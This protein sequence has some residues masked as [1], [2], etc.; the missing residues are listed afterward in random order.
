MQQGMFFHSLYDE[1]SQAYI[2]QVQFS[3]HGELNRPA[4]VEA[5]QLVLGRHPVLRT[6]L[7]WED[8]EEPYQVV[9]ANVKVPMIEH[10]W[11]EASLEEQE[12][13]FARLL[14]ADR[15][16]AFDLKVA[17]LMRV[18]L[19][20]L[21]NDSH[22]VLWTFHHLL[23][24]GWSIPLVIQDL[25][26]F[27]NAVDQGIQPQLPEVRPY[28][29]YSEWLEAQDMGKVEQFWRSNLQ[30]FTAPTALPADIER[31]TEAGYA[32]ASLRLSRN[33][34]DILNRFAR[35]CRITPNTLFQSAW[36]LLLSSCS[37]EEDVLYGTTVSGRPA[38]LPGVE[39]MVGLFINTLPV[40]VNVSSDAVLGPW[41]R[42]AQ[43]RQAELRLYEYSP[44]L[45]V[46]G[47]SDVPRGTPLFDSLFVFENIQ[48]DSKTWDV[49]D[50]LSVSDQDA[51]EQP[52]LPLTVVVLPGKEILLRMLYD[53]SR[54]SEKQVHWLL[55]RLQVVLEAMSVSGEGVMLKDLPFITAEEE[56]MIVQQWN[57]TS[58]A[59][60]SEKTIHQL[61]EEQV[62]ARPEHAALYSE[63]M[64]WSYMELNRRANAVARK[65]VELGIRNEQLIPMITHRSPDMVIGMLA[66]LKAG[67]AYVP[68]DPAY[69]SERIEVIVE[70]CESYLLLAANKNSLPAFTFDGE[71]VFMDE[72]LA[73]LEQAGEG[74]DNLALDAAPSNL[75]YV[76]YT[77][78]STGRPKG[79]MIEHRNV[80]RLVK[81]SNYVQFDEQTC[82]LQTGAVVFDAATLEVWGALLNGGQLVVLDNDTI[83]DGRR[84]K[85][86]IEQYDVNTMFITAPLLHQ[87][88]QQDSSIFNRLHTLMTGGDVL[89]VPHMNRLLQSNPGLTIVNAYGPTENTTISTTFSFT[90]EQP[91]AI[92]IGRPIANSSAYVVDRHLR[93]LPP[94][95]KGELIV[96]GDGVARGYRN[97]PDLT[98]EKFIESPFRQE[99]R[100]YRTGDLVR[101]REDGI[102]EFIGRIDSQVK[103]RGFRIEPGEIEHVLVSHPQVKEA[104]VIAVQAGKGDKRLVAYTVVE[105]VD[106]AVTPDILR[107]YLK[108]D[109]PEHMIPAAFVL[110][111]SFPL[112][113]NGKVDRRSLPAPDWR[114]NEHRDYVPARNDTEQMLCDI[115]AKVLG[116]EQVGIYDNFFELG[117]DSILSIQVVTQAAQL[118]LRLTPKQIFEHRLIAELAE[119]V[120][121]KPEVNAEQGEVTGCVPL[122]PIQRWFFKQQFTDAHHWNQAMM[123]T[124]KR[125]IET[126]MLEQAFT[127]LL[128]HHDALRMR[129]GNEECPP[130]ATLAAAEEIKIHNIDVSFL[131]V[132]EQNQVIEQ[133]SAELQASLNLH[134]GPLVRVAYFNRG[135]KS[136]PLLLIII[137]HLAVDGVSWRILLEDLETLCNQLC[138][139]QPVKLPAKTTSYK[140]WG[141]VLQHYAHSEAVRE[142][143]ASWI[144][145]SNKKPAQL[146]LDMASEENLAAV[147]TV[148]N[149]TVH[150]AVLSE[151]DSLALLNEV[152]GIARANVPELL[153]SAI[154]LAMGNW[155]GKRELL[156]HMEG[157]GREEIVE[158]VDLSRTVGWFTTMY[159]VNLSVVEASPPDAVVKAV[160]E[161]LRSIP[162]KGIGY[163]LLRYLSEDETYAQLQQQ[164]PADI[165]FNYLGRFYQA[166]DDSALFDLSTLSAG[167]VLSHHGHRPHILDI[168]VM[169]VEDR[170]HLYITYCQQLHKKTT[171]T[172][173]AEWI[174][175][176][177]QAL[178]QAALHTPNKWFTP[179]DFPLAILSQHQLERLVGSEGALA[180]K[181]LQDIYPLSSLQAGM[182]Y[183]SLLEEKAYAYCQQSVF[184][185]RGHVRAALFEN[186]WQQVIDKHDIFRTVFV[187]EGVD[188]PHQAVIERASLPIYWEDW[189]GVPPHEQA[190]K[191]DILLQE[192]RDRKYNLLAAPLMRITMIRSSDDCYKMVWSFHHI[193]LDGWSLQLVWGEVLQTYESAVQGQWFASHRPK[194]YK[195]F[196]RWTR[197]KNQHEAEAFWRDYLQGV[198]PGQLA[199]MQPSETEG[200]G[201]GGYAIK[202]SA[203]V[204]NMLQQLARSHQLTMGILVQGAWAY[205]LS[206]YSG[207]DQVLFGVTVAGRPTDIQ[208][209]DSMIG[210]FINTLPMKATI[211]PS[212]RLVDWLERLQQDLSDI[213]QYEHSSL[214]D[215]QGWSDVP[216]GTPLIESL[217][218]FENYPTDTAAQ[219][220]MQSLKIED[221]RAYENPDIPLTIA[222]VPGEEMM[223]SVL[224][225]RSR[226]SPAE[227][228]RLLGH[229]QA[230]LEGMISNPMQLLGTLDIL[231]EQERKQLIVECNDTTVEIPDQPIHELF[232]EQVA[233]RPD[234]HA[235]ISKSR[236]IT[237]RELDALSNSLANVLKERGIK[238]EE[239]IP[240]MAERSPQMII[241]MLAILK[242]GGAYV[243]IDPT[244]PRERIE[245]MLE[246]TDVRLLIVST[247]DGLPAFS[248]TGEVLSIDEMSLTTE[249][250][251]TENVGYYGNAADLAY[252]MYTSGSTGRPKGVMVEQRNI[253]RL[254]KNI[255][256]VRLDENSRILQAGAVV[257]DASTFEIWGALLNGGQVY[258]T[259]NEVILDGQRLKQEIENYRINTMFLTTALLHQHV[260]QDSGIFQ[261]LDTLLAGGETISPQHV[262][263]L[264]KDN[265]NLT[266]LHVYGPTENTTF[267]TMYRVACEHP[268]VVPIGSPIPNSTAYVVDSQLNLLPVGVPGELLVGGQG[269]ARGYWK[270]SDMT[271]KSFIPS[272]FRAGERCYRTGDLVRMNEDG[273]IEFIGRIDNQ[274]KIRGFRV[275]PGEIEVILL[276]HPD[277]QE[278]V[279][280]VREDEPGNKRLVAYLVAA[281][282]AGD[283]V[284]PDVLRQFAKEHLPEHMIPSAF[285]ILDTLPLTINGKV[286]R[287]ALPV[288]DY[289]SNEVEPEQLT[290]VQELLVSL[291]SRVLGV[292]HVR[293]TDDF[294]MLGGHSLMATQ[295]ISRIR[296]VFKVDLPLRAIFNYPTIEQFALQVEV[297]RKHGIEA[298]QPMVPVTRPDI[299]PLSYAQQRLWFLDQLEPDNRFYNIY[300]VLRLSGEFHIEAFELSLKQ[301]VKRHE[302]FRTT[303]VSKDGS[304][305][306]VIS[307]EVHVSVP[308]VDLSDV[309]KDKRE[310]AALRIAAEEVQRP[311][312]LTTDCLIRVTVLKLSPDDHVVVLVMHHIISDGW[313]IG[314]FVRELGTY[315]EGFCSGE[316][317]SL[318]DLSIQ[319]ADYALWQREWLQGTNRE[320]QLSYWTKKLEGIPTI[321]ELPA[322]YPRPPIQTFSGALVNCILPSKVV[323][324]LE[325]LSREEGATLYMTL[326][327]AFQVLLHRYSGQDS[328]CIGIPVANRNRPEIESIIGF[329]VNMLP[330]RADFTAGTT[331]R[332][333]LQQ[334]RETTLEAFDHQDLP[335]EQLVEVMQ[336]ERS[337]THSPLFQVIF[338]L[339]TKQMSTIELPGLSTTPMNVELGESKFDLELTMV[340]VPEGML[341]SF[342]YNTALF[343]AERIERMMVHYCTLLEQMAAYPDRPVDEIRILTNEELEQ[344]LVKWNATAA[345]IPNLCSHERFEQ[346][347]I[348][349]PDAIALV[350]E[351]KT[352]TYREL[353]ERSNQLAHYLRKL[354]VAPEVL[355][356]ICANR[357]VEFAIALLAV[358]KAGGVY[359]PIDPDYPQERIAYMMEH[360]K[361]EFLLTQQHLLDRVPKHAARTVCLDSDWNS[362][363]QEPTTAIDDDASNVTQE[364][365]AYV[366]YTSGS[367]GEPKGVVVTH[368]SLINHNLS[369]SKVFGIRAEDRVLQFATISFDVALEEFFSAWT[370]GATVVM[371]VDRLMT[372]EAFS[373]FVDDY[374]LTVLNL[375]SAYWHEWVRDLVQTENKPPDCVRTVIV[376]SERPSPEHLADWRRIVGD[377]IAWF[378]AYGPSEATIT[379]TIFSIPALDADGGSH[380]DEIPIGRPIANTQVYLLDEYM[381]P[382]P[383]GI[384]GELYIG[385]NGLARG[386]LNK[387]ELTAERFIQH[388][389]GLDGTLYR[390]GDLARY[391]EDGNIEFLGRTDYQVKIRGF[392]IE[393]GEVEAALRQQLHVQDA[394]VIACEARPGEQRLVAYAV[395]QAGRQLDVNSLRNALKE[396]LP[397]YMV[398]A[399]I[400]ALSEL[401][402]T[403]AGKVDRRALP[404]PDWS[405]IEAAVEYAEPRNITE[406]QLCRIWQQVLGIARVGIH[407]NFFELGGDSI[408]SIQIVARSNQAGLKLTPR[409]MFQYQTVAELATIVEFAAPV[410][411]EQGI[412]TGEVSLTPIQQWFFEQSMTEPHH[413]N[414]AV[415]LTIAQPVNIFALEQAFVHLLNHHDVLRAQYERTG[416][417]WVQ[418]IAEASSAYTVDRFDLSALSADEQRDAL[419]AHADKLQASLNLT[420][421]PLFK[422][423]LFDTGATQPA[424]LL[425]FAH[426][427]VVDGVSWRIILEDVQAAYSQLIQ[428]QTVTLPLKTT[429]YTAWSTELQS[430]AQQPGVLQELSYWLEQSGSAELPLD[431]ELSAQDVAAA[432]TFASVQSVEVSLDEQETRMLL[433]DMPTVFKTQVNDV[434][435]T[436]LALAVKG[437][438][439]QE[440]VLIHLEGHGREE[441]V[442]DIDL[443]RTVG[444]F[445]AVYPLK[446]DIEHTNSQLDALK[447]VKEQ[448][449]LVPKHGIGY[450]LLRYLSEDDAV[451]ERL[452]AMAEPHIIFNYLG[453]FDQVMQD[454]TFSLAHES[455]GTMQ[456]PSSPRS[457]PIEIN[458]AV[459]GGKLQLTFMYSENLHKKETLERLAAG[460][461]QSVREILCIPRAAELSVL[462]PSDFPQALVDQQQLDTIIARITHLEDLYA[463]S[464]MQKGM[465]FHTLYSEESSTYFEQ[466]AFSIKG[467]LDVMQFRRA[468]QEVV[469]RH[470]ILRTQL[471]VN[472]VSEP[473][474]AVLAAVELPFVEVDWQHLA[475]EEQA[476][477]LSQ[478]LQEDIDRG[479]D[480]TQ[481][482]LMRITLFKEAADRHS[483]VWSHHHLLIDGWSVPII[484][485]EV[486]HMYDSYMK[487][488]AV[489]LNDVRPFRDYIAWLQEQDM[490]QAQAFWQDMLRG[491]SEPT[492]LP[493]K[494]SSSSSSIA[495][496]WKTIGLSHMLS[497]RLNQIA[498][499]QKVTLN[500]IVQAA[501]AILLSR[502]S[503]AE[504]VIY[505]TTVSGRPA[506]FAGV[507]SMVGLF[508]NTLPVRVA[509]DEEQAVQQWLNQLNKQIVDI[510]QF[511]YS[512]LVQVQ[513]WS[514]VPNGIPLFDSLVVFQ[515]YPVQDVLEQDHPDALQLQISRA[516]KQTNYPITLVAI[517]GDELQLQV[518]FDPKLF[519]ASSIES[520]L[521]HLGTLLEEM[522]NR[523]AQK[524]GN[525]QL[526]SEQE[527]KQTLMEWNSTS[528]ELPLDKTVAEWFAEQVRIQPDAVAIVSEEQAVTYGELSRMAERLAYSFIQNGVA[529]G[530]IVAI[531][532]ER[533][534][535]SV[536]GMLGIWKAGGAYLPL[537]STYPQERLSY[538]LAEAQV[539]VLLTQERVREQL[540]PFAGRIVV[541][542]DEL[543][544]VVGEGAEADGGFEAV[545]AAIGAQVQLPA[546]AGM[547]QLAYVI[548]TSG[549]TGQPKGVEITHRGLMNLIGWHRQTYDVQ[550]ADRATM[551]AGVA[552][553][554]SV[555]ELWPYIAAGASIYI[556]NEETRLNPVAL[557]DWL[558][559]NEITLSFIPTPL[560]EPMLTLEWPDKCK[561]RAILTGGDRLAQYPPDTLPFALYNH[562]GPSESTV[563]AAACQVPT[564]S[565]KSLSEI[566]PSIG[567]P[568]ANTRV[569]ILDRK[570]RPVP[571]GVPGEMY[572]GGEGL[573]RGYMNRP[574]LTA[575]RFIDSPFVQG[576]RLYR[577][578]DLA[579]HLP[580]G[581]I[582]FLGRND[583]Q[584]KIRGYRIE[585][586]EIHAAIAEHAAVREASVIVRED[587]PGDK[588]LVA[589]IVLH[590]K[591]QD[592][593]HDQH[594][595]AVHSVR[596]YLQ[597]RLPDYMVPL[598]FVILDALPLTANGKVDRKQLPAP[599]WE[600]MLNAGSYV[601]PRNEV[602]R[603]LT[604]IWE[605][606]L[607]IEQVGIHDNF[608][609]LGGDSIVS[610]QIIFRCT[611]AGLK[612]TPKDLFDHQ[613]IA[614][615]AEAVQ[616]GSEQG[617][618]VG[619][620]PLTPHQQWFFELAMTNPHHANQSRL[621]TVPESIDITL[622][623]QAFHSIIVHHDALRLRF[624]ITDGI[625]EQRNEAEPDEHI[626][627]FIDLF[628]LST[629]AQKE[630]IKRETERLQRSLHITEGPIIRAA[631]FDLGP[632]IPARLFI[633]IHHLAIDHSSWH[634]L[635][636]DLQTAYEQLSKDG[637]VKLPLKTASFKSWAE[638]LKSQVLSDNATSEPEF[639]TCMTQQEVPMLPVD[640]HVDLDVMADVTTMGMSSKLNL[641]LTEQETADLL[642]Q[643]TAA[644]RVEAR[645]ILLAALAV[646][647]SSWTAQRSL[648][649]ELQEERFID[650][651][652]LD[653][654]RSVGCFSYQFP[655]CLELGDSQSVQEVMAAV[656]EQ[657]RRVPDNGI[658][659][660]LL[661]Y[662]SPNREMA[663]QLREQ[664]KPSIRFTYIKPSDQTWNSDYFGLAQESIGADWSEHT[665]LDVALHIN[666]YL[667]DDQLQV[668]W[669][670]NAHLYER[671]TIER[672]MAEFAETLR[673]IIL[674]STGT[675]VDAYSAVDFAEFGWDQSE[676]DGFLD[677]IKKHSGS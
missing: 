62:A 91:G 280:I 339:Q 654:S 381:R 321:L 123:L 655:W 365:A 429:S 615:L 180:G 633:A 422:S 338:D 424:K 662:A 6:S 283:S 198:P 276:T 226:F 425:L 501:W 478:F 240:I 450:G 33:T 104:L 531:C 637:T 269:V 177:L 656:K 319:Y 352:I 458:A 642:H 55:H 324:E 497:A 144:A 238:R 1:G 18:T 438:T 156:V 613:T 454:G 225:E 420:E 20:R 359:V 543:Q 432:N 363:M 552:F 132:V 537:D 491:I 510:R 442:G 68:I 13:L 493:M 485:S 160:K 298:A 77:S 616:M 390:T 515:N 278:A 671:A 317:V 230:V 102:I 591:Q 350:V 540:P 131:D 42:Q 574:D 439:G 161:Q 25:F 118:G 562:Y 213:R 568:I 232:R 202:L 152:P 496:D 446:I 74:E 663:R 566:A 524:I 383:I 181:T 578:G 176:E 114:A 386:Y 430:F 284:T 605:E 255:N 387:P 69:P 494:R 503:G 206:K 73:S 532:M 345:N 179:S 159:P 481:A 337:L 399:M 79:V 362:I 244:Y 197:Q 402:M 241:A 267:S 669:C 643:A 474:Q 90:T 434:L 243:P 558:L 98:E 325:K 626:L 529:S 168:N 569:Y 204:T 150:T 444:W 440:A 396:K 592:D 482:P 14:A 330:I 621:L 572:V 60:P 117:G 622:L 354:G 542:E 308:I 469:N 47:W 234:D 636:Q 195:E 67:G 657:L 162:N 302:T 146:P 661:K 453:Q 158:D 473:H 28:G 470:S 320:V 634:I 99:E 273:Q 306:Q 407:D 418:K 8:V 506:D 38:N 335:F 504:E 303:F 641:S 328:L 375:P 393:L 201:T 141:E 294:F 577:T 248:F 26:S 51:L 113:I 245:F 239:L 212:L 367:T 397:I 452:A 54:F 11:G 431:F 379:S 614:L 507:E 411:A 5:W 652:K 376:G 467:N 370:S 190:V 623:S 110:L 228:E 351:N 619:D 145:S 627:E 95:M 629:A 665:Q 133:T 378:N 64:S 447:K 511:E 268:D 441:L 436:A 52:D 471:V 139:N 135:S 263:R 106:A 581:D 96:G 600:Q 259:D 554:A 261:G 651:F 585:L 492:P 630:A 97:R 36:A 208:G 216:R 205:L 111:D 545:E 258:L 464:P 188:E 544:A 282:L 257:F 143:A 65:L 223:L 645:E 408:L 631:L 486:V 229:L 551:L 76:M 437:W 649:V 314:V 457:N 170:I 584:V 218:V 667:H 253:I 417:G 646:T 624:A 203:D 410:Q 137:H 520:M 182:L 570:L 597:E 199:I 32:Q 670:Y 30:G 17:P 549:S 3:L 547:D 183:E 93:L 81:H 301:I 83:L 416:S 611:Q 372:I 222:A 480:L 246:D 525:L 235:V 456:S 638:Q 185:L 508:I 122:L 237:Y 435:L 120:G 361:L 165:S 260:T 513:G 149:S 334:V 342:N 412:V 536:A 233:K 546:A 647:I 210:L 35:K 304:P 495:A 318:P 579:R 326:L 489:E 346:L 461:V 333:M 266:F 409:Q 262:N 285:I 9:Q 196:I 548:F 355:V 310:K 601:A 443:S 555:W 23:L 484:L 136:D 39:A 15:E 403:P 610:I 343:Q 299:L 116:V 71:V 63:G 445:T 80:I 380:Y 305:R 50:R 291:W 256:Y 279:V 329:F 389:L 618:V 640:R 107:D 142:E 109:L 567:R 125:P 490:D 455:T 250:A 528:T 227:M 421:G 86:A 41:L 7:V 121:T 46:Q 553:D 309:S 200:N 88:S 292:S 414:Q 82:M 565:S 593:Q 617:P 341:A 564:Q 404:A 475:A 327:T 668:E 590:Q 518:L 423:V 312:D 153:L 124:V 415:M 340:E 147:N 129:F 40:R 332:D 265:P 369:V 295:L 264:L 311:F 488:A 166:V 533:S 249:Q 219:Q 4:F 368:G 401:P 167:S 472:G 358:F 209:A 151:S 599:A 192:D 115:W 413:W 427:L 586:G 175:R 270:R 463:L 72:V 466:T 635:L 220:G 254:V 349:R 296:E 595:G 22:R 290:V 138:D 498:R 676:L 174:E 394:V 48:T 85:Q 344:V 659:Y 57:D 128:A 377:R 297:A 21:K 514:D 323:L 509:I 675:P 360:S 87:L 596:S 639:W 512:P 140:R 172:A 571:Q 664:A 677:A 541:A 173:F 27:Y 169:V 653:L 75:A 348:Q 119:Y 588:R 400:V 37:G 287:R 644:F 556:A 94:G 163:G 31:G 366:I 336:P 527:R 559:A 289:T 628:D 674:Q 293:I 648:F 500:T 92:P 236:V 231:T 154:V 215:I 587:R 164:E 580:S 477:R 155:T 521:R 53:V 505:G 214:I 534:I 398:P 307:P 516:Y 673:T 594:D 316:A 612:L 465:L 100:C 112:M 224:Y 59:Y 660:G 89:S 487:D 650:K 315:Y 187:W 127:H 608:F 134:D 632:G 251:E 186:A 217:V 286:D 459:S 392:R 61:F 207:N 395:P 101:Y 561:L 178:I 563:V 281:E 388:P 433:Q 105:Q 108:R 10:N 462:T 56:Q 274:V 522:A 550:A 49:N 357:S 34:T 242:A 19:V 385:G 24:D 499:T 130:E 44:L 16:A 583:D 426:H 603:S 271:N 66:I 448:L 12:E 602:E 331:V 666:C 538:M 526:L 573:A 184:T 364:N 78:G 275:E 252:V 45:Q 374:Q 530:D 347:A 58:I 2:T 189:S 428:D 672:L 449:R 157:H 193:L 406:L 598:A 148:A 84:M 247:R 535:E 604:A 382:V 288:P 557:R 419:R 43:A 479:F 103:I 576:E 560:A 405:A 607:G 191:L 373:K 460:Y 609:E 277:I 517:P 620:I 391:K 582:E 356:G 502:Y 322:D 575:E 468:W 606:V 589:Y 300:T 353:N 519:T 171:I 483:L 658:G 221:I 272:P 194:P 29:D 523:P 211:T 371:A 625:V 451:R 313:S 384:P 539:K 476:V 126:F 70:D